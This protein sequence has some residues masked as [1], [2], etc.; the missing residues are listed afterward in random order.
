MFER[1]RNHM[2]LASIPI[3]RMRSHGRKRWAWVWVVGW[4]LAVALPVTRSTAQAEDTVPVDVAGVLTGLG[5]DDYA[6]R[7]AVTHRLLSDGWLSLIDRVLGRAGLLMEEVD[8]PRPG[9]QY[10]QGW[11]T[12]IGGGPVPSWF[13]HWFLDPGG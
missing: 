1:E 3:K 9:C 6:E 11:L 8:S 13:F 12:G 4:L 5:D 7:Q 2:T 10:M